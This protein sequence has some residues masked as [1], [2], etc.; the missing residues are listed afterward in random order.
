MGDDG[1]VALGEAL[2]KLN[3]RASRLTKLDLSCNH[4]GMSHSDCVFW[5]VYGPLTA[6]ELVV[7]RVQLCLATALPYSLQFC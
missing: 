3:G 6:Y 1:G 7:E 4:L 2:A 5:W